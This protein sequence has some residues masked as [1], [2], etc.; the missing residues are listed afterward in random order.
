MNGDSATKSRNIN[1]DLIKI[2]AMFLVATIHVTGIGIGEVE[3]SSGIAYVATRILNAFSYCCIDLF[4]MVSGYLMCEKQIKAKR[5]IRLW[6]DVFFYSVV[7]FAV[8]LLISGDKALLS[9]S[10]ME[11]LFPVCFSKYWYISVYFV[12]YFL[13]PFYN[14]LISVLDK[15][16]FVWLLI[17]MLMT[18]SV[19]SVIITTDPFHFGNN[20]GYTFVW[21][22]VMYFLGAY[23][24]KYGLKLSQKANV[25]LIF[26][27]LFFQ[28]AFGLIPSQYRTITLRKYNSFVVVI[29]SVAV[30][31]FM[32]NMKLRVGPKASK[33][34]Q[35]FSA[36]S[37]AVYLT[38]THP[39]VFVRWIIGGFRWIAKLPLPLAVISIIGVPLAITVA[40]CLIGMIQQ[41]LFE[42][43]KIYRLCDIVA[44]KL[45]S[46]K[47]KIDV[48][49][50]S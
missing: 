15:K 24:K 16:S 5:I 48:E 3:Y 42:A 30:F 18:S 21:I 11:F 6:A 22:S 8:T 50:A 17:V 29:L 10:S 40:G 35:S 7:G 41:K 37:L 12:L 26:A 38:H 13:I 45:T 43:L 39:E 33:L 19:I 46:I 23:I 9:L 32:L 1:I 36:A 14:K 25:V 20:I 49:L 4:A 44:E 34:I 31:I 47:R 2:F 28:C 27:S